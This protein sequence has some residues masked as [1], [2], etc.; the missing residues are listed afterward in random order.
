M[1]QTLL[2]EHS[3]LQWG[4]ALFAAFVIGLAK[5]GLRGV[6]VM[7]VTI[8][9]LI[10]GS[11]ASTGIVLPLL[12]VADILAVSFY[13]RHADWKHFKL[14]MPWMIIGVLLGWYI[15]KEVNEAIF[16]RI[17]A[18]IIL[19]AITLMIWWE[20]RKSNTLPH[21]GW[22]SGIMGIVN[23]FTT[24]L[25]NLAGAFSNIYFLV[26]R[27]PKNEF[28]GTV[29]WLFLFINLFKIPF[30]IFSWGT[31]SQH[32]VFTDLLLVPMVLAGFFMGVRIVKR[33]HNDNYRKL[34]LA[35]TILGALV[36][37]FR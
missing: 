29:S 3:P 34:V 17:M 22:F 10:F 30:H 16:K 11:K 4:L 19:I 33:I 28:I 31:I 1:L 15:G 26:L 2:A 32:T 36:I 37:F 7:N 5:A 21:A 9:A 27:F 12:C 8:M 35:L 20:R 14:L 13:N 18:V 25:G 24:M 23:G 6:D